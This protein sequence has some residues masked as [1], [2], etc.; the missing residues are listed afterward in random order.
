MAD[1]SSRRPTTAALVTWALV[2]ALDLV[3]FL[4]RLVFANRGAG[5]ILFHPATRPRLP[6]IGYELGLLLC[7]LALAA[8]SRFARGVRWFAV[9]VFALFLL[10][11]TYHEAYV[12][13]FYLDA[14]VV[15]D[16]RLLIGLGHYIHDASWRWIVTVAAGAI[17]YMLAIALAAW[18]FARFQTR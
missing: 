18:T 13:S 11:S 5:S 7:A 4:P 1:P 8:G 15:D 3:A 14:A 16:W 9:V 12:W 10:F 17:A 6:G 2:L